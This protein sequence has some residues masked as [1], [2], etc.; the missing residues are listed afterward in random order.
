[1]RLS[2]F[3]DGQAHIYSYSPE[4]APKAAKVIASHVAQ[5]RLH[6]LAGSVLCRMV[7]EGMRG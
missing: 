3:Y 1:M 4:E 6:P 7:F 2:C 5:G